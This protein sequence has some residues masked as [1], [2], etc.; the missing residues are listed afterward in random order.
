M[1]SASWAISSA[2][3]MSRTMRV[4]PAIRRGCSIFQT[5]L[6]ARC[7]SDSLVMAADETSIGVSLQGT[8]P[9]AGL[10][11]AA[12]MLQ[13]FLFEHALG[14]LTPEERFDEAKEQIDLVDDGGMR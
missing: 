1:I 5:V 10:E 8:M 3:E 11:A 12:G 2:S 9:T 4:S 14:R 7:V 13:F 6:I